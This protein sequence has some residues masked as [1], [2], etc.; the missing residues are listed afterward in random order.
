[1][2]FAASEANDFDPPAAG[3]ATFMDAIARDPVATIRTTVR[4]VSLFINKS[5]FITDILALNQIRASSL[6]RQYFTQI[7]DALKQKDLQLLRDVDTRWSSTLLMIDRA[8]LLR[9]VCRIALHLFPEL[10]LSFCRQLT[11]FFPT[12]TS[13]IFTNTS[14]EIR[15]GR[16]WRRSRGYWM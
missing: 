3:A 13:E 2:E 10:N 9:A 4:V 1:M 5:H 8:I 11:N 7:L 15:N 12:P 16:P 6:R 14:S